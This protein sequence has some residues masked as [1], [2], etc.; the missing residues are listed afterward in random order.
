MSQ[1]RIN[2]CLRLVRYGNR[3]LNE[4]RYSNG[5]SKEHINKKIELCENLKKSNK[6]FITEAIFVNG[7]R[8]DILVLDDFRVVEIVKTETNESILR[9]KELYP[10]GLRLEVVRC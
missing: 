9:K 1:E 6:S 3:K 5:E 4:I 2:E 8:A 10:K 7:M